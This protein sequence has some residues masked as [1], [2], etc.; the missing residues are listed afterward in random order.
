[1]AATPGLTHGVDEARLRWVPLRLAL[2][3]MG[4]FAAGT[5]LLLVWAGTLAQ[6]GY[7]GSS[8]ALGMT[9]VFALG[10]VTSIVMAV[11]Y[12]LIPASFHANVRGLRRAQA[13]SL[14]Y[15]LAVVL[16]AISLSTG[17]FVVAAFAGPLLA[18]AVGL[19]LSQMVSVVIRAKRRT[20]AGGFHIT[21][22]LSLTAVIVLGSL[23]ATSL[24]TDWIGDPGRWLEAKIVLAVAGWLGMI[25]VGISYHTVRGLNGSSAR[26]RL[27]IPT[28]CAAVSGLA[29]S[30]VMILTGA[31]W[32]LRASA[33]SLLLVASL[34]FAGDV[35][36][37]VRHHAATAAP[38][39]WVGQLTAAALLVVTAA[40]G[41]VAM[42]GGVVWAAMAVSG[43]LLGVA[44]MAVL[45]NGNR[46]LPVLIA[47]RY[48]GRGRR[49]L[50]AS[51]LGRITMPAALGSLAL[52]WASMQ[53]GILGGSIVVIRIGALLLMGGAICLG[54]TVLRQVLA[55]RRE[56]G[57]PRW[58]LASD[59]TARD[60]RSRS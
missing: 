24:P 47:N 33:M 39:T 35:V 56:V 34:L 22:F 52:S 2:F 37:M 45:A 46:V 16:F 54:G 21:A 9:H 14:T 53:G 17:T 8:H 12:Q 29:G 20:A 44:P 30:V 4:M 50:S 60:A 38:I 58:T 5:M 10:F 28:L 57:D 55:A 27:V 18:V 3:G 6:P 19:F 15:A 51:R 13:M 26:P 59:S 1:M 32:S 7:Y 11:L 41:V 25:V 31:P 40:E 42:M 43:F 36:Y 49:P 23:L 48:D